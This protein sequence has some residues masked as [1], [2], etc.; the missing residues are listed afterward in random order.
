MITTRIFLLIITLFSFSLYSYSQTD[1][2]ERKYSSENPPSPPKGRIIIDREHSDLFKEYGIELIDVVP[3]N[4]GE[5]RSKE[6]YSEVIKGD[7][8]IVSVRIKT[9]CCRE[10][11]GRISSDFGLNISIELYQFGYEYC[12]CNC[13]YSFDFLVLI[14]D[15]KLWDVERSVVIDHEEFL[16]NGT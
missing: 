5:G 3:Y 4:C 16:L 15:K 13:S 12:T 10:F 9:N 8:L 6:K 7:T 14:T 11:I 1:K 2:D